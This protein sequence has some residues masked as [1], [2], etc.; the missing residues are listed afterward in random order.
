MRNLLRLLGFQGSKTRERNA[1]MGEPVC[2]VSPQT[3]YENTFALRV[4]DYVKSHG[5]SGATEIPKEEFERLR[6]ETL[7]QCGVKRVPIQVTH[8][9][10]QSA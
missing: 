7:V 2:N 9:Q 10:I 6:S 4:N 5:Y 8:Y 1:P 3:N